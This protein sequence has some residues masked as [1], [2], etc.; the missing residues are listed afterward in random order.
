MAC[1]LLWGETIVR[2]AASEGEAVKASGEIRPRLLVIIWSPWP[3]VATRTGLQGKEW[4]TLKNIVNR[5]ANGLLE[6]PKQNV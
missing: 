1:S 3:F 2:G 5:S 4:H 6:G